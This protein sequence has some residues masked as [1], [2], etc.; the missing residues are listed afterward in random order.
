MSDFKL[1]WGIESADLTKDGTDFSSTDGL[2]TA[3]FLSLFLD[4]RLEDGDTPPDNGQD[5]RGW[6]ADDFATI[7]N[8][9]IGSRLWLLARSKQEQEILTQAV[10]YSKEA[11]QWLI[12]DTVAASIAVTASIIRTGCM[13][14]VVQIVRPTGQAVKFLYNYNWIAQEAERAVA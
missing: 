11:L 4:R 9:K 13:G 3:V 10:D 12:D 1:A 6:W 5:L 14:I 2:E 8:D 7:P